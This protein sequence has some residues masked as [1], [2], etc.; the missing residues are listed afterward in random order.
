MTG[1]PRN[2]WRAIRV[3]LTFL[4]VLALLVAAGPGWVDAAYVPAAASVL[5]VF[6]MRAVAAKWRSSDSHDSADT[7]QPLRIR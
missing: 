1:S 3:L 2:R 4:A 6:S 7:A 5:I